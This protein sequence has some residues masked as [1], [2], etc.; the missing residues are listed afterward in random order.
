MFTDILALLIQTQNDFGVSEALNSGIEVHAPISYIV[1]RESTDVALSLGVTPQYAALKDSLFGSGLV[2][3]TLLT[4]IAI[5]PSNMIRLMQPRGP[6]H[7][8]W[9]LSVSLAKQV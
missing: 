9:L 3:I 5:L 8:R 2:F 1:S 4:A 6:E 7:N